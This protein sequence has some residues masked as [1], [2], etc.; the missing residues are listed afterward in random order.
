MMV[1]ASFA[2]PIDA[3]PVDAMAWSLGAGLVPGL[4]AVASRAGGAGGRLPLGA[5][6]QV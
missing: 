4:P 2:P 1:R 3:W 5:T 6:L